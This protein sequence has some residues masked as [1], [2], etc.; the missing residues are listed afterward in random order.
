MAVVCRRVPCAKAS[1]KQM[2]ASQVPLVQGSKPLG[3]LVCC[4]VVFGT[5][6]VIKFA[7]SCVTVVLAHRGALH[8]GTL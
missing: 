4:G 5:F 7:F 8:V 2:P 3:L 6:M 1:L